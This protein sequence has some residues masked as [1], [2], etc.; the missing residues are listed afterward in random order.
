MYSIKKGIIFDN[1]DSEMK[2]SLRC[3]GFKEGDNLSE[4]FQKILDDMKMS[5][6]EYIS[7]CSYVEID[8]EIFSKFK[9]L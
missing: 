5:L 4:I 3:L 1:L 2:E 7:Q 9:Y 6:D 8:K